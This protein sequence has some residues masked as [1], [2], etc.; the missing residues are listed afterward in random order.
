MVAAVHLA[1]ALV[2]QKSI[3]NG[4]NYNLDDLENSI[5]II[6]KQI[7]E[8]IVINDLITTAENALLKIRSRSTTMKKIN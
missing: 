3:D 5:D 7:D 1:I 8:I 2:S 4:N 6:E